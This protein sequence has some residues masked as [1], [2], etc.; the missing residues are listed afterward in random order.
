MTAIIGDN[1]I[2]SSRQFHLPRERV[3]EAWTNPDQLAR[4]WGPNGFTNTF[5]EFDLRPG[6]AWRYVMHGPDGVDYP[7]HCVF[8]EIVA[9]E[10]IVLRHL[11]GH[12][13]LVTAAFEDLDGGTKVVFRQLFMKTEEFEEAKSYCA[14]GN[15]QNLDRLEASLEQTKG[16]PSE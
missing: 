2:I 7:N 12:E 1:E 11:S 5:H 15:E 6:G 14:E 3:F 16:R 4:W 10:R 13:F 8:E 9:L